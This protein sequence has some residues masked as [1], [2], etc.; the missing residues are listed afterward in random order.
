MQE[1]KSCALT[2]LA[3]SLCG[4]VPRMSIQQSGPFV[5]SG[6]RL[7]AANRI[8]VGWFPLAGM[9]WLYL[10]DIIRQKMQIWD[11]K[12]GFCGCI[13]GNIFF[14]SRKAQCFVHKQNVNAVFAVCVSFFL[15][16]NAAQR[17]WALKGVCFAYFF[18]I[19]PY[20]G[21]AGAGH[22]K[23]MFS[24]FFLFYGLHVLRRRL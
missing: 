1:S 9:K 12:K 23:G 15:T 18:F 19:T 24:E 14:F 3:I 4:P 2:G 10:L 20:A 8:G 17:R 16:P 13:I 6:M 11:L 21:K 7:A 22:Q 5:K